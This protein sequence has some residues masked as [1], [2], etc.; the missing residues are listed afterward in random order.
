MN[1]LNLIGPVEFLKKCVEYYSPSGEEKD[2]SLFLSKLLRNSQ[3]NVSFDKVGNLIAEKGGGMP[4]LLLSSHLDTIPGKLPIYIENGFLYGRGSVD[5]KASL[6]AIIY[7]LLNLDNDVF[8]KGTIIFGGIIREEERLIGI[9]EFLKRDFTPDYA[10]FG[11]PTG[12]NQICIGYKGRI[13]MNF[14]VLTKT[15]HVASSWQYFNAIE[16]CIEIWNIIKLSCWRLNK[17]MSGENKKNNFF[18]KI[19]PNLTCMSGG[20]LSNCVPSEA[21][22]QVDIR[23]P[24]KF[25]SE[26]ILDVIRNDILNFK[27]LFERENNFN[28]SIKEEINSLV[29]AYSIMGN[30]LIANALRWAIYKVTKVKPKLIKKTGTTFINN[31]G[32]HYSIPSITYGP[33]DP[34]LEHTD[35]ENINIQEYLN[36]IKVYNSFYKKFFE[37]YKKEHI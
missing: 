21:K 9:Q 37:L 6:A 8:S 18:N 20:E 34:K 26:D 23:F 2:F 5:C 10:L 14:R 11:E 33:G 4:T 7:S 32:K 3:F 13:S 12:I 25:T 31:I 24:P 16:I 28:L 36:C 15:G 35:N 17:N 19:I 27:I 1:K 29:E 22:I 30:N